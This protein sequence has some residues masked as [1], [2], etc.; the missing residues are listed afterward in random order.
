MDISFTPLQARHPGDVHVAFVAQSE[1]DRRSPDR[2]LG[3]ETLCALLPWL[4]G[5]AAWDDC[6]G[7]AL[8]TTVL[9]GPAE[10]ER[11]VDRVVLVG[12]GDTAACKD[13]WSCLALARKAMGAA[14]TRC[15]EL[16]AG[17]VR[18]HLPA[19]EPLAALADVDLPVLVEELVAGAL[20]GLYAYT[21]LKS[22]P[23]DQGPM[24]DL[25]LAADDPLPGPGSPLHKALSRGLAGG[26]GLW[27]ARDLVNTPANLATPAYL[28]DTARTLAAEYGFGLDVYTAGE[29]LELGMGAFAA[30]FQANPDHA[31]LL[32]LDTHGGRK[33]AGQSHAAPLVLV[34][35]GVTFDTGGISLKPALNMEQMKGDMAGAA[36]ILGCLKALGELKASQR[37]VAII[38]ATDN[39]PGPLA[40]RPGDVVKTLAGKTVEII[41]T[42]AE[43]RLLLCDALAYAGRFQPEAIIDVATLTGAAVV[44]LGDH[45]A[46]IYGNRPLL[47]AAIQRLAMPVGD[48]LWPMPLWDFY[49][50]E[51][52]SDVADMKNVGTRMGGSV[53]AALFLKQFVPDGVPWVHLDIAGPA[54]KTK[55][56]P[57]CPA[58]GTGFATRTL[59]HLVLEWKRLR[60]AG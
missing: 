28:E 55:A 37:V 36:A 13:T 50:E 39:M 49:F 33:P 10:G 5:H 8:S 23:K 46:A 3:K 35:K 21:A 45:V 7:E 31:R 56:A 60:I 15:R 53:N 44:A 51:L 26:A 48:L 30:V 14:L 17:T 27:L 34:G 22:K 40:V 24:P 54:F 38:P 12:L 58:G 29:V 42:D 4:S 57:D 41:N 47:A 59:L 20:G 2:L 32:V 25:R 9:Y 1:E 18:L 11:P 6:S 16:R 19:L 52:K 43:G